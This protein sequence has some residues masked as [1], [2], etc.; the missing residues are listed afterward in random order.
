M[1]LPPMDRKIKSDFAAVSIIL[2]FIGASSL[3]QRSPPRRTN[4]AEPGI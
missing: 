1:S 4:L 3:S 2:F